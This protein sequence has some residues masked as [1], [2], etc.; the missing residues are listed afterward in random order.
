MIPRFFVLFRKSASVGALIGLAFIAPD[1]ESAGRKPPWPADVYLVGEG[2]AELGSDPGRA[3]EQAKARALGDLALNARVTVQAALADVLGQSNGTTSQSLESR[4]NAYAQLAPVRLDRQEFVLHSPQRNHITC[5]VGV[6]RAQYDEQVRRELQQQKDTLLSL[7]R[8]ALNEFNQGRIGHS[9]RTLNDLL[10]RRSDLFAD[11]P[12]DGPPE[13]TKQSLRQS[14][15][16]L[17]SN[18]WDWARSLQNDILRSLK[19][20][21]DAAPMYFDSGGRYSGPVQVHATWTG[22]GKAD[23]S[24]F[25]LQGRWAH[26]PTG[27]A[28]ETET[29]Q[30]GEAAFSPTVDLFNKKAAWVVSPVG[31]H[32]PSC[33]RTFQRRKSALLFVSGSSEKIRRAVETDALTRL[34]KWPWDIRV[35]S[36]E[37]DTA[38]VSVTLRLSAAVTKNP[39]GPVYQARVSVTIEVQESGKKKSSA[40]TR[41]ANGFGA[42]ADQA[43]DDAANNLLSQWGDWLKVKI[44]I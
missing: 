22:S 9:F 37:T 24:G 20:R 10:T 19:L 21:C 31:Q 23:L 29:N 7:A 30:K 36:D 3:R 42:T 6:R 39:D 34:Q 41:T 15:S 35:S 16:E 4:V 27:P 11:L 17:N 14:G 12:F 28:E 25:P 5:R 33:R 2:W 18:F 13:K 43:A 40:S 26:R 32:N 1:V 38:D 8:T 44:S